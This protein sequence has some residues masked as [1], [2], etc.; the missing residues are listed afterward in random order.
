MSSKK[1]IKV[2]EMLDTLKWELDQALLVCDDGTDIPLT[3]CWELSL[4]DIECWYAEMIQLAERYDR[5]LTHVL[6]FFEEAPTMF[7]LDD[8]TLSL[9]HI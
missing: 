2:K 7:W 8:L 5:T 6:T 1:T 4:Q 9:I 3:Q